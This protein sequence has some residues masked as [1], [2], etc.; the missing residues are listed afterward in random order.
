MVMMMMMM[1]T[2]LRW[3]T[4]LKTVPIF[5]LFAFEHFQHEL[6]AYSPLPG[7][8]GRKKTPFLTSFG[9]SVMIRVRW[10]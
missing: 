8:V 6:R 4:S 7:L 2:M 9:D 3:C 1:M 5:M 10:I